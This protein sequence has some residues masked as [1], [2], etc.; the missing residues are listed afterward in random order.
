MFE[1][2]PKI[3]S[4]IWNQDN[5]TNEIVRDSLSPDLNFDQAFKAGEGSGKSGSF[6]FFSHDSKFIIKTMNDEERVT[7]KRIFSNYFTRVTTEK[8]SLL[9]RIYGVFTVKIEKLKPVHLILMGN[10]MSL[11]RIPA[12]PNEK[13]IKTLKYVFDLKGSMVNRETKH[14]KPSSTLK[15]INLLNLKIDSNILKFNP[16][17]NANIV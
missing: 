14:P 5:I 3:F 10:S 6:F 7:F 8:E 15:D 1:L 17:D 13:P 12:L 11:Q 4:Y 9:A 2:A 16:V